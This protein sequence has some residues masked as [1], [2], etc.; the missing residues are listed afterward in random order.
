MGVRFLLG[1]HIG[2]RMEG[3]KKF[4]SALI[5]S[6]IFIFSSALATTQEELTDWQIYYQ[7]EFTGNMHLYDAKSIERKDD[8]VSVRVQLIFNDFDPPYTSFIL[9]EF[10]CDEKYMTFLSVWS[11]M[12]HP[13]E[14][15]MV[16]NG[17][18][19]ATSGPIEEGAPAEILFNKLCL[20]GV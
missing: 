6:T 8:D 4:L 3:M 18:S 1:A 13:D 17:P 16:Q 19:I 12:G 9:V 14:F 20:G 11:D 2:L 15:E 10:D 7:N 5:L